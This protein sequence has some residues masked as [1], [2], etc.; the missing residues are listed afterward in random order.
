MFWIAI[1]LPN[2]RTTFSHKGF[3]LNRKNATGVWK[4]RNDLS[5]DVTANVQLR[6]VWRYIYI[7][8]V[9]V[10]ECK[11]FLRLDFLISKI[12]QTRFIQYRITHIIHLFTC[13]YRVKLGKFE[14]IHTAQW[15][16]HQKASGFS[17][18]YSICAA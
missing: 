7:R 8:R 16:P 4:T 9:C 3:G 5:S 12:Q 13:V 2:V 18:F 15:Q 1:L 17:G 14:T 10:V 6:N 11:R